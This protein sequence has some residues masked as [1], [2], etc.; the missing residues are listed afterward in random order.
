[1]CHHPDFLSFL[2]FL[3][4]VKRKL[5]FFLQDLYAWEMANCIKIPHFT[6]IYWKER[7]DETKVFGGRGGAALCCGTRGSLVVAQRLLVCPTCGVQLWVESASPVL[8]GRFLTT[9]L[10]WEVRCRGLNGKIKRQTN[11]WGNLVVITK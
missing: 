3:R 7:R 4:R 2:F 5:F 11:L 8:G 1:M 9:G 6:G 10:P